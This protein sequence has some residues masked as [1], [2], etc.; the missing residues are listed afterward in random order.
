MCRMLIGHPPTFSPLMP[1]TIKESQI[2]P[3]LQLVALWSLEHTIALQ[4][5]FLGSTDT[6]WTVCREVLVAR[7]PWP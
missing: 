7:F 3:V 6:Q 1:D 2:Q 5:E 4:F